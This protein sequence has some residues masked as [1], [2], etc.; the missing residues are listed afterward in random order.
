[1]R[2]AWPASSSERVEIHAAGHT[3]ADLLLKDLRHCGR[4]GGRRIQPVVPR[5]AT[6]A[7]TVASPSSNQ[8]R[9]SRHARPPSAV[10]ACQRPARVFF[11]ASHHDDD[12]HWR[13]APAAFGERPER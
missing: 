5:R 2:C 11:I 8:A 6:T 4:A 3:G 7:S 10:H 9:R 12:V 13:G 1:M